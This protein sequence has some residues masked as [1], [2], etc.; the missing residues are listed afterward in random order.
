MKKQDQNIQIA[1]VITTIIACVVAYSAVD[2]GHYDL[3]I[4]ML[5]ILIVNF[6]IVPKQKPYET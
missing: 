4:A 1:V 2:Q 3:V 6:C 5:L